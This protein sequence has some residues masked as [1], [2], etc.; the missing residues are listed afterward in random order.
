MIRPIDLIPMFQKTQESEKFKHRMREIQ[1]LWSQ[2]NDSISSK[3][4]LQ[5]KRN[6]KII[7]YF[8]IESLKGIYQLQC[9]KFV[10]LLIEELLWDNW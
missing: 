7:Q 4:K 5:G 10:G 1:T 6:R 8:K 2:T 3:Y 9:M